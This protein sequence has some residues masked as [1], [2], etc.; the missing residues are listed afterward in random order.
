VPDTLDLMAAYAR[1]DRIAEPVREAANTATIGVDVGDIHAVAR[2]IWRYIRNRVRWVPDAQGVE[3]VQ[4]PVFTLKQ[5]YGDCDGQ[6]T[7]AAS[8]LA[9]MGIPAGFEAIAHQRAGEFDHVYSVYL[10]GGNWHMLDPTANLRPGPNTLRPRARSKITRYLHSQDLAEPMTPTV[11]VSGAGVGRRGMRGLTRSAGM[12][13]SNI[14]TGGSETPDLEDFGDYF[15]FLVAAAPQFIN[16]L[17]KDNGR[18]G[19]YDFRDFDDRFDSPAQEAG[20][21]SSTLGQI[22]I[23][24]AIVTALGLGIYSVTQD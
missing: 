23:G 15:A 11:N 5:K 16:A 3:L 12:G 4:T 19:D 18:R 10:A 7:L 6:A 20:F 13:K 21:F 9:A 22:V 1:R 8:M 14:K 2:S 24:G 17:Q